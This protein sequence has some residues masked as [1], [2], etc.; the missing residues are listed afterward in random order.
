MCGC[1]WISGWHCAWTE[2][3]GQLAGVSSF[4][5]TLSP[6]A[7]TQVVRLSS[8]HLHTEPSR[9]PSSTLTVPFYTRR[10]KDCIYLFFMCVVSTWLPQYMYED[11]RT[12]CRTL[13][14]SSWPGGSQGDRTQVVR[15]GSTFILQATFPAP[16]H[17]ILA[18]T[19]VSSGVLS[20]DP[21]STISLKVL[22]WFF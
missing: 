22:P 7:W 4:L 19:E 18:V 20:T 6:R 11:Q 13:V 10:S 15:P 16:I 3:R 12:T 21:L 8:K 5:L 1:V 14:F 17:K 9:Q 2:V